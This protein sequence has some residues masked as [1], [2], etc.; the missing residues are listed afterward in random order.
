MVKLWIFCE[1]PGITI[2]YT[3]PYV[4]DKNGLPQRGWR[5]IDTMKDSMLI[6]SGLPNGFWT[7][8]METANY[9]QN[10]L[11]DQN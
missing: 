4:H 9:L 6:D 10:R 2:R 8:A 3:A 7:E 11:P 5:T 1:K